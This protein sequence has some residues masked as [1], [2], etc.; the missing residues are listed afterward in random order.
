MKVQLTTVAAVLAASVSLAQSG[1]EISV[2][3]V[4][5]AAL[6]VGLAPSG[7]EGA[8][9][10]AFGAT[11]GGSTTNGWENVVRVKS[12]PVAACGVPFA[13][14]ADWKTSDVFYRFFVFSDETD[15]YSSYLVEGA[16]SPNGGLHVDTGV[17]IDGTTMPET[18]VRLEMTPIDGSWPVCGI[19]N[20]E[21]YFFLGMNGSNGEICYGD[22]KENAFCGA[23]MSLNRKS[24]FD[25]DFRAGTY[26]VLD[27]E[28]D[29]PAMLLNATDIKR[30][31]TSGANTFWLFGYNGEGA[32]RRMTIFSA[33]MWQFGEL[34][35]NMTPAV[36]NGVVCLWDNVRLKHLMPV[37]G[38]GNPATLTEVGARRALEAS[39]TKTF[40]SRAADDPASLQVPDGYTVGQMIV[41]NG[42]GANGMPFV[43]TGVRPT[44]NTRV[45][46]TVDVQGSHEYWFGC[47]DSA[48]NNGAFA[49]GNDAVGTYVGWGGDGRGTVMPL[50][51]NGL[52]VLDLSS[53]G[54]FVDGVSV[55]DGL[56]SAT[57]GLRQELYLFAQNRCGSPAY[58]EVSSTQN[59]HCYS[60]KIYDGELLLCDYVPCARNQDELAGFYD[61]VQGNFC[62]NGGTG[63]LVC[64]KLTKAISAWATGYFGPVQPDGSSITVQVTNPPE[65]AGCT[66]EWSTD[67]GTTWSGVQPRFTEGG[68]YEVSCRI[69]CEG[70]EPFTVKETV[71]VLAHDPQW[72]YDESKALLTDGTWKL[73]VE[74]AGDELTIT[75]SGQSVLYPGVSL[76]LA[77]P[78][79]G[80]FQIVAIGPS[81]FRK[82]D[83]LLSV[84][85]PATLRE[86]AGYAFY[87]CKELTTVSPFLPS[88][89]VKIGPRAFEDC[90]VLTGDLTIGRIGGPTVE[91]VDGGSIQEDGCQFKMSTKRAGRI[92]SV[93]LNAV[94]N[95]PNDCFYSCTSLTN[96]TVNSQLV[97]IGRYAFGVCSSLKTV[98]PFLPPSV[99]TI[100]GYAFS[101]CGVLAGDLEIGARNTDIAWTSRYDP[102]SEWTGQQFSQMFALRSVTIR[103]DIDHVPTNFLA[104]CSALETVR[105]ESRTDFVFCAESLAG[106]DGRN[107]PI[108]DLY[109]RAFA[110]F[111]NPTGKEVLRYRPDYKL[112]FWVPANNAKWQ[113]WV[114]SNVDPFD[115]LDPETKALYYAEFGEK[116]KKPVGLT[117][118]DASPSKQWLMWRPNI[119]MLIFVR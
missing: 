39:S 22:G 40:S 6:R 91:W 34:V 89:I 13:V 69:S 84:A 55:R 30:Q 58:R 29:P 59:I 28:S 16:S 78:V 90:S 24:L 68:E 52:H 119:G 100:G 102:N 82:N 87:A 77:K 45:V 93:T 110:T 26:Q 11:D 70:Y 98:T 81:A 23:Y 8:L 106:W 112:R 67:G 62:T 15:R 72:T 14:P 49:M 94:T 51:E 109:V 103:G 73:S 95:V 65:G 60:C 9:W 31:K 33:E 48:W 5:D 118:A 115:G 80:G 116:A 19:A 37:N 32:Q 7:S 47:W 2:S 66:Y 85:L 38:S 92:T 76:D 50:V 104:M 101:Q 105:I 74:K 41:A 63:M 71:L 53:N 64:S 35:A 17:V 108:R 36:L 10:V 46:M 54:A 25:L 1:R 27:L 113:S 56:G 86:I 57:F 3:R 61:L 42:G 97:S 83:K 111:D 117:H 44:Q 20:P 79:E 88:S 99:T 12:L 107:P 114:A 4:S 43:N 75:G 21:P 18:R 96:V